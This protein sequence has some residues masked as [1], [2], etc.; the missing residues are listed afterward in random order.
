MTAYFILF[1]I[2]F[3]GIFAFSIFVGRPKKLREY[4]VIMLLALGTA[5]IVD[6][7]VFLRYSL[8]WAA[9]PL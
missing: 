5:L 8:F 3:I 4:F 7:A 9:S 2:V 6:L 1:L